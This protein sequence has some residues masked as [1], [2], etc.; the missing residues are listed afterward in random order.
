MSKSV[1]YRPDSLS[2][3]LYSLHLLSEHRTTPT[4][5]APLETVI[6]YSLI[7]SI[8][9]RKCLN[10]LMRRASHGSTHQPWR[11]VEAHWYALQLGELIVSNY[12][13]ASIN[14]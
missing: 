8:A 3:S 6:H 4:M 2:C 11:F 13:A 14:N 10:D 12:V 7:A 9:G 5:F 1:T